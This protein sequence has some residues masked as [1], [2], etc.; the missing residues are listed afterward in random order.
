MSIP[1]AQN[2]SPARDESPDRASGR[3]GEFQTHS[4]PSLAEGQAKPVSGTLPKEEKSAVK[5]VPRTSELPQDVV[6]VHQDP[7]SKNQIIIQ[8][9]DPAKQLILQVPSPQE[10]NVERGIARESQQEAKLRESERT[11]A[12]GSEGETTHGNKL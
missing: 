9:L 8:Y 3:S 1:P 10:L 7:E 6:E 2:I 5:N 12:T 11:A 4:E